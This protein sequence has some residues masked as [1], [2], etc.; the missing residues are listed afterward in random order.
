MKIEIKLGDYQKSIDA[1]IDLATCLEFTLSWGECSDD[2]VDLL[3]VC[4][5]G[6][7]VALDK[8]S[9]FPKYRPEKEKITV[10]GRR[11]LERL[12]LKNIPMNDI[13]SSGTII[14]KSMAEALPHKKE[15]EDKKDFFPSQEEG[16]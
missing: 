10:Y 1:Q 4:S 16:I 14:L 13:Y 11:V 7:G 9:L 5:A 3:R 2:S 15:V 6:I 12:L 8:E